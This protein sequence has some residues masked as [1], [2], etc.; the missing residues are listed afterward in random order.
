MAA[1][2]PTPIATVA[3]ARAAKPLF[4]SRP[5]TAYVTS[6][7]TSSTSASGTQHVSPRG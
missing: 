3:I 4:L 2:A 5:R 7:H 6:R 1:L